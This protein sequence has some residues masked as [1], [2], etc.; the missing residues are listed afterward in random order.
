[1]EWIV[2][3]LFI[4]TCWIAGHEIEKLQG[5]ISRLEHRLTELEIKD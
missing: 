5:R 2:G 1:M 3:F 4:G